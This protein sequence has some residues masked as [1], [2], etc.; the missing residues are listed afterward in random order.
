MPNNL[1]S[2]PTSANIS[3]Q[4]LIIAIANIPPTINALAFVDPVGEFFRVLELGF[5]I[6]KF[7]KF[8]QLATFFR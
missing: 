2:I 8:L 5:S 1:D 3:P 7:E 6:K 4:Q